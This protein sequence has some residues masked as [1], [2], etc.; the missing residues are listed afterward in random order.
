M[1][2]AQSLDEIKP[3]GRKTATTTTITGGKSGSDS[4]E[5]TFLGTGMPYTKDRGISKSVTTTFVEE[6]AA[7]RAASGP[8]EQRTWSLDGESDSDKDRGK[9]VGVYERF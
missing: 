4:D 5:E 3:S 6:R 1:F 2:G 8:E 9:P 7:S